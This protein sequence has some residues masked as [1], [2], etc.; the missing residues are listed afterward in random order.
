[1]RRSTLILS[2]ALTVLLVCLAI[3]V[4][5]IRPSFLHKDEGEKYTKAPDFSLPDA[6]GNMVSLSDVEGKVTIVNFWAS[7]S[8]YSKDELG[9]LVRL[10]REYGSDVAIVALN[11][12]VNP[13]DGRAYLESLQLGEELLFVYDSDDAYFKKVS[14]FAVPETL[15]LK[16][17]KDIFYHKH[18]PMTYDEMKVHVETMLQ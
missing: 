16:E 15:F 2:V 8:P 18:G 11:R 5:V 14:G 9:A 13:A 12:D 3:F 10:K 6:S 4:F 7:W 17:N 1:M